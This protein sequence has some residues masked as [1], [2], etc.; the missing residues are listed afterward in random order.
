MIFGICAVIA[1]V[2]QSRGGF[3]AALDGLSR[4]SDPLVSDAPG[5]FN[6][7]FGPDPV[8]LLGVVILTSLGTWG[9]PQ[10]VQKFYAIKSEEAVNKAPSFRRRSRSSWLAA[11]T[12]SAAS[13]GSF[14]T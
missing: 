12:S 2:L 6:S 14:P 3:L 1:A 11:V 10:M 13:D 8:N 5:I 9:L 4:V 7:F